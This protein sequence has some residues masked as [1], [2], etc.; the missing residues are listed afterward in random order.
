MIFVLD[1]THVNKVKAFSLPT[2]THK[3]PKGLVRWLKRPPIGLPVERS[4]YVLF[5]TPQL[6]IVV[7][8]GSGRRFEAFVSQNMEMF[9]ATRR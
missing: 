6:S 3:S 8:S 7:F 5:V 2:G 1:N 9:Q 4:K